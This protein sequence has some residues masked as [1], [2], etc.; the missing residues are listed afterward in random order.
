[1]SEQTFVMIKP[2]GVRR[3]LVGEVLRR[4]ETKGFKILEMKQLT[5]SPELSKRHYEEHV[6]KPFYPGLEAFIT[7]GPVVAFVLEGTKAVSVVRK[8]VGVTDSAEAEP[9]TIRGDFSLE[10]GENIIHASDS[11]ESAV[12]EISNFLD[13]LILIKPLLILANF[14]IKLNYV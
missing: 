14:D 9:G 5:I 1:M 4:F 12:R 6:D 7:S 10:K 11:V 3:G 8:M 13:D 2:D